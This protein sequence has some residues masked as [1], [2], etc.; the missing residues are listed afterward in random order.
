MTGGFL[1]LLSFIIIITI[2][3][4][5]DLLILYFN[6]ETKT[7]Q[8]NKQTKNINKK[9]AE[10]ISIRLNRVCRCCRHLCHAVNDLR[11]LFTNVRHH[12][13]PMNHRSGERNDETLPNVRSQKF[14]AAS[15]VQLPNAATDT[16][17]G[18]KNR[19]AP[20][21]GGSFLVLPVSAC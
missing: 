3:W 10:E 9:Q 19:T 18:R 21:E 5:S 13:Q 7:N 2:F 12:W 11:A 17:P 20:T 6:R 16:W 4:R 1:L 15:A 14:L 8:T